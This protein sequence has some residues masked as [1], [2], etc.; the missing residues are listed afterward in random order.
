LYKIACEYAFFFGRISALED[1]GLGKILALI[2]ALG[3]FWPLGKF[4]SWENFGF[5]KILL[6]KILLGKILLGK[7]LALGKMSF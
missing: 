6:G 2:L 3:R 5:G 1:S 7:I 4:W